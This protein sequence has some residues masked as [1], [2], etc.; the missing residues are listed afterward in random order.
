[1]L[2]KLYAKIWGRIGGRPWT[3]I[4]RY[5]EKREPTLFL[6]IFLGLGI[7]LFKV[8]GRHWWQILIVFLLGIVAGHF[9]W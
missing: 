7:L 4:V 8:A 1:M 2:E 3:E 6:L 9:W 5:E